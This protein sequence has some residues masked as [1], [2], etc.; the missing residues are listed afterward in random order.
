MDMVERSSDDA[1]TA[2]WIHRATKDEV[3]RQIA[4]VEDRRRDGA[5]MP[6]FGVAFAVKDNIDVAGMP[7]TAGCPAFSYVPH[8][9]AAVVERL[10]DAGAIVLGKTNLDQFATGLVGTRSPYG[11]PRN[12]FNERYIPGGSSSGSA[13]AVARGL[14]SFALGTDTAGSGRIPAAFANIVGLKPSR[15]ALSTLGVVPACRSLDCVSIF[16][17][18]CEDS[19]RIFQV[20]RRFDPRDPFARE[21]SVETA[22]NPRLD[23]APF[24][25]GVPADEHLEFFGDNQAA[26]LFARAE[27]AL[28]A[29]GGRKMHIDFSPFR[30]AARLL[31][32]GPWVAERL[33]ATENLLTTNPDAIEP[34]VRAVLSR[35]RGH[36]AKEVFQA[37]AELRL[38][39]RQ[40][41][42]VFRQVDVMLVPT[43]PTLYTVEQVKSD[44]VRLN[45]NLGYYTNF[46]NLLDLCALAVPA[47]FRTDGLPFGITLMAPWGQ[48]AGLSGLGARFHAH[49]SQ[50]L[51]AST[52]PHTFE[53]PTPA[54]NVDP[55]GFRLAV[56]GAHLSG[57]PL[58]HQ[59]TSL[60][61]R[62]VQTLRT[63]PS[64]R[65]FELAGTTPAK[66]GLVR[67]PAGDGAAIEVEVWC[68]PDSAVGQF[69]A[70][71]AA[72]LC[73]GSVELASGEWVHGFLC[74][75]HA[76]L[77]AKDISALGGWRA[78]R[79]AQGA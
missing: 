4:E 14:A 18:T 76:V 46:V 6:L 63:V 38:L 37:Q 24:R 67:Q 1:A 70:G 10:V 68:L 48:D 62:L 73:I 50:T 39:S 69:L 79:K 35:A 52:S 25:F 47:G 78:Y 59:L 28:E 13:V 12:P 19:W 17:L 61:A 49:A 57:E 2:A 34:T 72:P 26:A 11:V 53:Q 30:L 41:E 54:A 71:V 20:A 33:L 44:P 7:T 56:V 45:S 55:S 15:G 31:Y 66:P 75:Q 23:A 8:R 42:A 3:A 77:S 9:S 5:Q 27:H 21:W 58:N 16:A 40:A 22:P 65:L 51:G 32:D 64:Y 29:L 60:G 43:A 74:E 36:S